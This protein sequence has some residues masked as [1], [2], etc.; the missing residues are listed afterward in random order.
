LSNF[1]FDLTTYKSSY[2]YVRFD[3]A[4]ISS[5]LNEGSIL[6]S[7]AYVL[8]ETNVGLACVSTEK[9]VFTA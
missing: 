9:V 7:P 2:N 6:G 8:M 5:D 1:D 3:A 4:V